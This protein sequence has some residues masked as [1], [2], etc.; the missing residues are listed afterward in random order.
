VALHERLFVY[1][2]ASASD[3]RASASD[4]VQRALGPGSSSFTAL[5]PE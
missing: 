5:A 2:R 4:K 3:G 1:G